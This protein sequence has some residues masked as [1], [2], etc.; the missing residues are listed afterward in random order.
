M[1][2]G[3]QKKGTSLTVIL[4]Y[5]HMLLS[6]FRNDL[7]YFQTSLVISRARKS[8][9]PWPQEVPSKTWAKK[10]FPVTVF[11][12][13]IVSQSS[14]LQL[15]ILIETAA[16]NRDTVFWKKVFWRGGTLRCL[17]K[18]IVPYS[19][20]M[21]NAISWRR[22]CWNVVS[23]SYRINLN[24]FFFFSKVWQITCIF[25]FWSLPQD[26]IKI[27]IMAPLKKN[28]LAHK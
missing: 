24:T 16:V 28:V 2:E 17:L 23:W 27:W 22:K 20:F 14:L 7:N 13:K 8:R 12:V 1:N 18:K 21:V 3:A 5:P 9:I 11:G 15:E 4:T 10:R 26:E 6:T 19:P 25:G